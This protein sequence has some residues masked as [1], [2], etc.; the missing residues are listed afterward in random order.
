MPTLSRFIRVET[1]ECVCVCL[2]VCVCVLSGL[3]LGSSLQVMV[4][5][6]SIKF[7]DNIRTTVYNSTLVQQDELITVDLQ[8][9][10]S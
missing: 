4:S 10:Q 5:R 3:Y 6:M 1:V 9:Y 8:W 2:C 7:K